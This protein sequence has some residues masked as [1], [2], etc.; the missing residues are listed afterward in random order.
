GERRYGRWTL[1]CDKVAWKHD[2]ASR[3]SLI[4]METLVARVLTGVHQLELTADLSG[5][6]ASPRLMVNSNLDKQLAARLSAVA[7]EEIARAEARVRAEVDKLVAEKSAPV[8]A[9][10]AEL[11]ADSERRIAEARGR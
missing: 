9:R 5:T 8:K 6:L 3:R 1:R 2:S 7:G 11:R 10:V 4:T